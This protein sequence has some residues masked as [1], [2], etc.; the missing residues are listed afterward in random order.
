MSWYFGADSGTTTNTCGRSFY[1]G[2]I[3]SGT[4]TVNY[5]YFVLSNTVDI[6]AYTYWNVRGPARKPTGLHRMVPGGLLKRMRTGPPT[7]K[8]SRKCSSLDKP[9]SVK[10]PKEPEDGV[11]KRLRKTGQWSTGSCVDSLV[12]PVRTLPWGFPEASRENYMGFSKRT[13]GR[14]QRKLWFGPKTIRLTRSVRIL[15]VCQADI[16][17]GRHRTP[18]R[19]SFVSRE[20]NPML[21]QTKKLDSLKL[22]TIHTN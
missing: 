7:A 11:P 2:R 15:K 1:I 22:C 18:V 16:S 20:F 8:P 3:G 5:E 17:G 12:R 19:V 4:S 10:F 6:P 21:T 9:Y 13:S 14:L